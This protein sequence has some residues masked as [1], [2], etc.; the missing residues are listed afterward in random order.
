MMKSRAEAAAGLYHSGQFKLFI[1]T[2]GV[3]W[4]T[5]FGYISEAQ[6]L[7]LYMAN[8]GV[9]SEC[10]LQEE[11]ATTTVE[12]MTLSRKMLAERLGERRL[13][14]AIVTSYFHVVRSVKLAEAHIENA[15]IFGVKSAFPFDNPDEFHMDAHMLDWVTTESR[16]LCSDAKRGIISDFPILHK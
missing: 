8:A 12:N 1:A 11:C 6:A 14:L 2:G 10:I 4:D 3:C 9:P 13:R 7:T 5:P 16:L 15:D